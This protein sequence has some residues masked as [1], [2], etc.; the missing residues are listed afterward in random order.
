[1]PRAVKAV[2]FDLDGTLIRGPEALPGAVAAVAALRSSGLK[3]GFCTQDSMRPP[4]EI[5]A[6]LSRLG[7][8]AEPHDVISSG[9]SAAAYLAAKYKGERIALFSGDGLRDAFVAF[10]A[11]VIEARE[12]RGASALFVARKPNFE[13]ADVAG[14]CNCVWNG[15]KY[16]AVGYD[17]VLPSQGGD[18][19]G[20]G[21]AVKAIEFVTSTTAVI[22]GK[23]SR[24]LSM[25]AERSFGVPPDSIL[26]VGD[27][28]DIDI[29]LG[30]GAGWLT[31][32]V[33]TGATDAAR[34]KSLSAKV[35]P[36]VVLADVGHLP[37]WLAG[38]AH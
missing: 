31:A 33:L 21:A 1:M 4:S 29:K 38:H 18:L 26:M 32:L 5:A 30:K 34:A 27:Q 7:F 25:A 12:G 14:A 3:I 20:S 24:A 10:G 28:V 17:N 6:K 37:A 13:A 2:A 36:D 19:P 8:A 16:Y 15:A 9:W 23:P 35:A 11:D 22:L